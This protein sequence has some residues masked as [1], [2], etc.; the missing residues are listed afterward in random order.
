M[1]LFLFVES[2]ML[3]NSAMDVTRSKLLMAFN[4][5]IQKGEATLLG[6]MEMVR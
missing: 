3:A 5:K 1:L 4:Y 6:A 2:E